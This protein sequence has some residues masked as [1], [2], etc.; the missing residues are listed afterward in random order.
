M[1]F[2]VVTHL[3]PDHDSMLPEILARH[4]ALPVE[5]A[6]DGQHVERNRIYVL[7]PN[8]LLT[9]HGR[10]LQLLKTDPPVHERTPIDVFFSS[11]ALDCGEYAVGVVL[12]GSGSD[13]VLGVKAIKEHGGVTIAQANDASGP[14]FPSMPESAVASGLV[15]FVIPA[16]A[17]AAKLLEN[18]QALCALDA[19]VGESTPTDVDCSDAARDE[20]YAILRLQTGH[21]FSGYK[22]RTF[23]RRIYRRVQSRN[24]DA[25]ASYVELLRREPDEA[26]VL[27]RDLL[28]NVTSFF[29]D[30]DAFDSLRT[31]VIPRLFEG[32]GAWDTIRIWAP[33]CAT[34]EE[35]YSIAILLREQIE[36]LRTAP[37]VTIFATDIDE[38]AIAVA[39]AGTYPEAL[40]ESVSEERRKRFFTA[41]PT[42]FTIAKSVR[43]LCVF[44]PHS[45]LRD[46]PFSRMDLISCRNV[47]IY[48]GPKAQQQVLPVFHYA[49]RPG[50]YLFL[51]S[52][53]TIG[54]FTDL[55]AAIDKKN[56]VFQARV[57]DRPR[58]MPQFGG[59]LQP[60]IPGV[61][62]PDGLNAKTGAQLQQIVETRIADRFS[63]PHVVVTT[64]G[65]IV[66]FSPRTRKFLEAPPGT[67]TR[68]L[69][70]SA[71]RELRLDLRNALHEAFDTR[72]SVTRENIGF[73]NEQGVMESVS[74]TVEPVPYPTGDPPLFLVVFSE[75]GRADGRPALADGEVMDG[76]VE[77]SRELR[78]TRERLQGTIEE[79]ESALE[80][81]K[82]SNEEMV[83]L[84]EELQS[85][86]EELESSKEEMQS[87][88]EELLTVNHDLTTKIEDLD[89]ANA[90]LTNLFANTQVATIFLGRTL[91][92]RSFT[93]AA[94]GLFNIIAS[95]VGRSLSDFATRLDYPDLHADIRHVLETGKL[96]E[97]HLRKTE[98]EHF[99]ARLVAYR[100]A[101][102]E[103]DGVVATFVDITG[104]AS[105]ARLAEQVTGIASALP[106]A[107]CS[108]RR[109]ADGKCAFAYAAPQIRDI[110]GFEPGAIADD[111]HPLVTRV[112]SDDRKTLL[113]GMEISARE[114][115]IWHATFRYD[116]PEKG[117]VWL[118]AHSTPTPDDGG[119][120]VWHG[121]LRDVS[122]SVH[123]GRALEASEERLR[124]VLGG[125]GEGIVTI[126]D[127]G[128]VQSV[129][130]AASRMFGYDDG[131]IIGRNVSVLMPEPLSSEH[132]S[133]IH[134]FRRTGDAR[135]IGLGREVEGRHKDGSPFPVQLTVSDV[136]YDHT[137]AFVGVLHDLTEQRRIEAQVQ[138][139]YAERL[140]AMGGMAV[141]LAHEINQP[142]SASGHYVQSAMQLLTMEP[143]ARPVR[144]EEMLKSAAEQIARAGRIMSRLRE[145]VAGGDPDK[146]FVSLHD[147]I[148]AVCDERLEK[149]QQGAIRLSL[150]L[151][152]VKDRALID[153]VQISQ[154]L[155]NL[156][157]NAE[158][159]LASAERREVTIATTLAPNDM[160][161][162]DVIDTGQG[163]SEAM[164]KSLF[165]PFVTT[166]ATGMGVGLTIS[167]KIIER[168][169]GLIWAAGNPEG[170]TI[171][172]FTLPLA[173]DREEARPT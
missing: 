144:V 159:A 150:R 72:R 46:P 168:H 172:S 73:E 117:L 126:D 132:D 115:S 64:E 118:E 9:I 78:D 129:N 137:H 135:I 10:R 123:A 149:K 13:G 92:I 50:G 40:L 98:T 3:A 167:R 21:D 169:Y 65:E 100:N 161:Q 48:F 23:M 29:R 99:L 54:R 109:G 106:G 173:P 77:T 15:D 163:L 84:N 68:Q 17:M 12:S 160:I 52:S 95:D 147:V 67:P 89:R 86:N 70:T 27:F 120:V 19:A 47:L 6:K 55:F 24:C 142:L 69:L 30:P 108:L 134:N 66:H 165:E 105:A 153:R 152:A 32:R 146:R 93:P 104:L 112:D 58:R 155:I 138:Q 82:S 127:A 43:D 31:L 139:L 143:E 49:L 25:L 162:V 59:G 14:A 114:S 45:I 56:C 22:V 136:R 33:G 53:E 119:A 101:R 87:L 75:P 116:H 71:R 5:V 164:R 62:R 34:G 145:F 91:A 170:G 113:A 111:L 81:L 94:A 39:R 121:Y 4:A 148:R 90:D 130:T 131:E 28:I 60:G 18:A 61:V 158:E 44:S 157:R 1:A 88:N 42:G 20:I 83:S 97:R 128:I 125:A 38:P 133:H 51:G 2:V 141:G 37:R 171:L 124:A 80:E 7:P 156:I 151:D 41:G 57:T 76:F 35:V 74:L 154:V 79:Y 85:S 96:V 11:L 103:I 8:A 110:C 63:P 16:E 166:K 122:D 140:T 26:I 107:I 36:T 102:D